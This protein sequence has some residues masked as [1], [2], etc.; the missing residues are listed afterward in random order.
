[1]FGP[2]S[3]CRGLGP[4]RVW[5]LEAARQW[6]HRPGGS[7]PCGSGAGEQQQRRSEAKAAGP[8]Q[9]WT[10]PVSP[11]GQLRARLP[12]HLALRPLDPLAYPDGSRVLVAVSGAS[13]G[14]GGPGDLQVTYDEAQREVSIVSDTIHPQASVEVN[15]PVKFDLNIKSSGSGNIK[16]N[17]IECDHCKIETEQGS[18]ILQSIKSQKLNIQSKGGEVICLGTVYG[19]I[20]IHVSDKSTVTIDK[21]Q[22]S[23]VNISTEDG[24]LKAKYLYTESSFLSSTAGDIS[25]GSIHG[26]ITLK[27][28]V[29]NIT[30]DSSS[31]CLNA[32]TGQGAID[33]YISQL[34]TVELKSHKGSILVKIT[35]SLQADIQL[36]AKVIDVN[37]EVHI[38]EKNEAHQDNIVTVTGLMNQASK[39][40]K[41]I[42]ADAPK[43]SIRVRSQNWF[44]SM[45]L[46]N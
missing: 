15:V 46:Q 33:V 38:Q 25:L 20:D 39:S 42:K 45:K 6:A 29:G 32:L 9:E 40:G 7:R 34:G 27:S 12:C 30:V 10:L 16:V 44:Q 24:L 5:V 19:N 4:Y 28:I 1:M 31:G 11:F 36:S 13:D 2:H 22:G 21:L 23:S 8:R 41:W 43:G 26:D 3:C 35:P 17:N 37:S 18:S 14:P